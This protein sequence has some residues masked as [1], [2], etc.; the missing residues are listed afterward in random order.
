MVHIR[1]RPY[2]LRLNTN[3]SSAS[4]SG[5]GGGA[6]A[7]LGGWLHDNIDDDFSVSASG[8]TPGSSVPGL[9]LGG[10]AMGAGM[11][12][13][14]D[15]GHEHP[16]P[17]SCPPSMMTVPSQVAMPRVGKGSGPQVQSMGHS[18]GQS[19]PISFYSPR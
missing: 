19:Q 13:D 15:H 8:S 17:Q 16:Q 18:H 12:M 14:V 1:G 10:A 9:G 11:G 6:G 4:A 2:N 3:L 5:A 7:T